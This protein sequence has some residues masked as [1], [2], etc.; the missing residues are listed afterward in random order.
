LEYFER[1]SDLKLAQNPNDAF[2]WN[3]PDED[4]V[5]AG[6]RGN[7]E[8]DD[9]AEDDEDDGATTVVGVASAFHPCQS[10]LLTYRWIHIPMMSVWGGSGVSIDAYLAIFTQFFIKLGTCDSNSSRRHVD[11]KISP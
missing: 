6:S 7:R 3:D 9:D 4:D 10:L 8:E 1:R 5:D 11:E 2:T